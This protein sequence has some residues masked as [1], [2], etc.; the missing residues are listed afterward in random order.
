MKRL[1][2]A[3]AAIGA[4]TL[5]AQA[6]TQR[7][8]F[9]MVDDP[10]LRVMLSSLLLAKAGSE[11]PAMTVYSMSRENAL[12]ICSNGLSYMYSLSNQNFYGGKPL[13][14]LIPMLYGGQR[15]AR[16]VNGDKVLSVWL[17]E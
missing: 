15:V 12:M 16:Y 1:F 2:I 14:E 10:S 17:E 6:N 13:G 5:S 8:D 11:C 9:K 4:L 3:L 7:V